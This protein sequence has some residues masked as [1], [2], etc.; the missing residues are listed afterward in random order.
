MK[1]VKMKEKNQMKKK[2]KIREKNGNCVLLHL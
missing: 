2:I 1:K